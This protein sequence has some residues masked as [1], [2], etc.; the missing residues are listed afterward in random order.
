MGS[1]GDVSHDDAV[2]A[3]EKRSRGSEYPVLP[4]QFPTF[5]K[6]DGKWNAVFLHLRFV[7]FS[8]AVSDYDHGKG[9][10]PMLVV[11]PYQI[12]SQF[13]AG[14]TQGIGEN[15]KHVSTA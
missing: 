11:E 13:V 14:L 8:I 1:F 9:V 15:Q 2:F 7:L 10:V 5:L 3:D 6:D 4:G 12:R